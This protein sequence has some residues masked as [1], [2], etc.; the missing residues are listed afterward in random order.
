MALGLLWAATAAAQTD[1]IQV[2][3]GGL[4]GPAVLNLTLHNNYVVDGGKTPAFEGAVTADRS[5]NGVLEWALG[6]TEW[7]EAGLYL[8]L[9]S[10]DHRQGWELDGFKLRTLFAVPDADHRRFFYGSNFEFS[11]NARK[12]DAARFTSEVRPIIG[13]HLGRFDVIANPILDTAYDGFGNLDFA[14][15]LRLAFNFR[16][17]WTVA[18]EEYADLGPLRG[19]QAVRDQSHQLFAVLHHRGGLDVEAGIGFGLTSGSDELT[20]KLILSRDLKARKRVQAPG[21]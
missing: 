17:A 1:E 19:F 15:A 6:A 8:P 7:F 13:W 5:W 2:Y 20:I 18:A 4:A 14:P 3:D 11:F 9:Y 10:H 16:G 12:W 21:R